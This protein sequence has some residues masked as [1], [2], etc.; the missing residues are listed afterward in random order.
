VSSSTTPS[1]SG[2]PA[3]SGQ[4]LLLPRFPF[5][6]VW[7]P[8]K[9]WIVTTKLS[10]QEVGKLFEDRMT[11][12]ANLLRQ[13]NNYFRRATWSVRRNAISGELV[14][15]CEPD[16]LVAVGFGSR[17]WYLDVS[18]DTMVCH[19]TTTGTGTGTVESAISPGTYTTLF[20]LYMYPAPVY[21][22]DI[23][24]AIKQ[25]DRTSTV[26]YPWSPARMI[27]L[28][29]TLI[30]L[31]L[32]TTSHSNNNTTAATAIQQTPTTTPTSQ[33]TTPTQPTTTQN[34]QGGQQGASAPKPLPGSS[35]TI[36]EHLER[37]ATGDYA[38][39]FALMSQSYRSKNPGWTANREQGDPE[40][41]IV[42]VGQPH[43]A[44][45][46]AHVYVKFYARDRN[47][48]KGSDTQ[49]RLFEGT[50]FMIDNGGT[51]RYEPGG[52]RLSGSVLPDSACHA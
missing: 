36:K 30:L 10:A 1:S 6:L 14:A 8:R 35:R 46:D 15:S 11:G 31:L 22:F 50:V 49:C 47:P 38:G 52:N 42:G 17:K 5:R 2:A 24:K 28:A 43:Y 32:A 51:W 26:K 27:A 16:G 21:A 40:I 25:A 18:R 44:G 12:K 23:V 9:P 37:L 13:V 41:G 34:E 39:A 20:G 33:E 45:K 3:A 4:S 29:I 19:T 7:S 48:A